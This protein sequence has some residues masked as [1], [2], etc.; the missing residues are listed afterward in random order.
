MQP[1][2]KFMYL[3]HFKKIFR[4]CCKQVGPPT[5]FVVRYPKD[6][7]DLKDS[8]PKT[9]EV[10]FKVPP[11]RVAT[12]VELGQIIVSIP[13]RVTKA[14]LK[15]DIGDAA[16]GR[17]LDAVAS[18]TAAILKAM[19]EQQQLTMQLLS[20][21]LSGGLGFL[22]SGLFALVFRNGFANQLGGSYFGFFNV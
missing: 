9:H 21:C 15:G 5:E 3:Q 7:Q 18:D 13:L 2:Q 10:L 12:G 6:P 17:R 11:V 14:A 4:N 1:N 20:G 16:G 8:F 22:L 19:Q